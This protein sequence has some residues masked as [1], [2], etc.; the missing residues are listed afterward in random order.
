LDIELHRGSSAVHKHITLHRQWK[1][2][3][4]LKIP[5]V[6]SCKPT[7]RIRTSFWSTAEKLW[8]WYTLI[9]H[10]KTLIE[11]SSSQKTCS[12]IY[13]TPKSWF[14][15]N[16]A[17]NHIKAEMALASGAHPAIWNFIL[18]VTQKLLLLL[19]T[20][21]HLQLQ[22]IARVGSL[23][24]N[25]IIYI[26]VAVI[27]CNSL[28]GWYYRLESIMLHNLPIMLLSISLPIM[29]AFMLFRY[30]LCFCICNFFSM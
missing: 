21:C 9:E 15:F 14:N 30:A 10:S 28:R 1:E 4:D 13:I 29:L 7:L 18:P 26:I 8:K 6:C 19:I 3:G 20:L 23:V 25:G 17:F 27:G 16:L 24:Q 11:Q 2:R 12:Y 5:S 22:L